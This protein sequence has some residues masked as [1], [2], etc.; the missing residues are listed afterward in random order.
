MDW[1][2]GRN[3]EVLQKEVPEVWVRPLSWSGFVQYTI[4]HIGQYVQFLTFGLVRKCTRLS[5]V[6]F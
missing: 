3:R 1:F 2:V 5:F 4:N 6:R